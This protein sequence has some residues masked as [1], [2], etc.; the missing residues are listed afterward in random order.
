MLKRICE[1]VCFVFDVLMVLI[2]CVVGTF[3]I[4]LCYLFKE[5]E[6]DE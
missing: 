1:K 4:A 2:I 5:R 6:W 3:L